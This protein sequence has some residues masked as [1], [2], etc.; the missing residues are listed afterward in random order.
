MTDG[1]D[2]VR[3]LE[4]ARREKSRLDAAGASQ[5]VAIDVGRAF[6]S[7]TPGVKYSQLPTEVSA[8]YGHLPQELRATFTRWLVAAMAGQFSPGEAPMRLPEAVQRLYPGD[9]QRLYE[10]LNA[11]D[12][13]FNSLDADTVRKDLA[14][15]SHRLIP[16]GAEYAQPGS[17]IPRSVLFKGGLRQFFSGVL[18]ILRCGGIKNFFELH[19]HIDS[20]EQ[21][22]PSGWRDTYRALAQ[23]LQLN[24]GL[25]GWLSSSWFLD[26]QLARISP[27]L[28]YLRETPGE[29][30]LT[31]LFVQTD[32]KGESGALARSP[33]RRRL[34]EAGQ[35]QPRIYMRVC[36]RSQ[37]LA[38]L[39]QLAPLEADG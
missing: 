18:L 8:A 35:Y 32:P 7:L 1:F 29:R 34:F 23:L 3:F 4:I 38:W 12:G 19:A 10:H 30:S 39:S 6:R 14:I 20:L 25:R 27:R 9:L 37:A 5:A 13:Y 22:S 28:A 24:P 17:G 2:T 31:Y 15:L 21:F 11:N 36:P 33:T 16:V 26:P